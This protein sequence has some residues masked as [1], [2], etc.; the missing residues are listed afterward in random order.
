M[1]LAG[2]I[3][4]TKTLLALIDP[5]DN[6]LTTI[7]EW[8][9]PSPAYAGLDD[10]VRTAVGSRPTNLSVACFGV[11][12]PVVDGR[13][14][15]TNLPW[16]IDANTLAQ[17][18]NV[19]SVT[20]LNDVEAMANSIERLTQDELFTL[21]TGNANPKGNRALIAAGTGLGQALIFHDGNRYHPSASEG[22]HCDFAPDTEEE[23]RL[24]QFLRATFGH[25][26]WERVVSGMG[27]ANIYRFVL[28]DQ[29]IAEP[30]WLTEQFESGDPG[31]V[32][33]R[34][35][36]DHT[37]E[38]CVAAMRLFVRLYGA[39]AGNLALKVMATG[40][41]YV[42]GGIGPKIL[43]YLNDGGFMERFIAKGRYQHILANIPV[44]LILNSKSALIGAAHYAS[45]VI[46]ERH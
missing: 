19:S 1:I 9:F 35:A 37:F 18:L 16:T 28:T 12:G 34:S 17:M 20:L 24:L 25:V 36:L 29:Q 26:S 5:S 4:G 21:N 23:I 13:C 39:E 8:T 2:D 42:G 22:G 33:S 45:Q 27:L 15:A 38:P 40:G 31:T 3:G 43:P 32:I 44:T 6:H 14:E 30:A 11:A 7:E 41:L 10:V 46:Q